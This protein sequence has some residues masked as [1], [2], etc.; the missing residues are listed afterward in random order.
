M[1]KR[2]FR[3]YYI[4]GVKL[5]SQSFASSATEI[6]YSETLPLILLPLILGARN[7]G[8]TTPASNLTNFFSGTIDDILLFLFLLYLL[9]FILHEN[10]VNT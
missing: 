8:H 4:N 9:E 6:E 3:S 5:L 2:I 1:T 7:G 10:I